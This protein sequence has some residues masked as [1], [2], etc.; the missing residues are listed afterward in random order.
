MARKVLLPLFLA[1]FGL[2]G[3]L[4]EVVDTS[5]RALAKVN[6]GDGSAEAEGGANLVGARVWLG[7]IPLLPGAAE[8]TRKGVAASLFVENAATGARR[9]SVLSEDEVEAEAPLGSLHLGNVRGLSPSNEKLGDERELLQALQQQLRGP[10]CCRAS[11]PAEADKLEGPAREETAVQSSLWSYSNMNERESS[12]SCCC[13]SPC[14]DSSIVFPLLFDPQ[15]SGGLLAAVPAEAAASCLAALRVHTAAVAIGDIIS[16]P[17]D[18]AANSSLTRN[19]PI[20]I[21]AAY[22]ET[23]A[24]TAS[25]CK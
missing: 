6:R 20:Q 23:A 22:T 15:T 17:P 4:L 8:L 16:L 9:L 7:R 11:L 13:C 18:A 10:C 25:S 19:K 24:D 2:L 5:N 14:S 1:G 21:I 3:H 12:R